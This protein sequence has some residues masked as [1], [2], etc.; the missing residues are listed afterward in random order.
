MLPIIYIDM[1]G[2]VA[3]FHDR[4]MEY[5]GHPEWCDVTFRKAVLDY[6][7]FENLEKL[8]NADKLLKAIKEI[9]FVRKEFLTSTGCH[10]GNLIHHEEAKLQKTYWLQKNGM[11]FKPNFVMRGED[12][13]RVY[14]NSE[15]V[16]IDD[17]PSVVDKFREH[18]GC[19]ILHNNSDVDS[20]IDH[21]YD[22]VSIMKTTHME[23]F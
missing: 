12:K 19:A 4:I 10:D 14:A 9:S 20:T 2:V 16:L 17:T 13:G 15:S 21:L 22:I 3:N 8:S 18:G 1:D 11:Y 5:R 7:I 23:R 6:K